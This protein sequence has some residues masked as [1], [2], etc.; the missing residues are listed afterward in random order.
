MGIAYTSFRKATKNEYNFKN[1]NYSYRRNTI[2][3][4]E[5]NKYEKHTHCIDINDVKG[6][7]PKLKGFKQTQRKLTL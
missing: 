7:K 1:R 4:N 3:N 5:F 6:F 2:D